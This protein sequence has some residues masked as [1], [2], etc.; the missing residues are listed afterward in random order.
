M[1]VHDLLNLIHIALHFNATQPVKKH[2]FWTEEDQQTLIKKKASHGGRK[3][4]HSVLKWMILEWNNQFKAILKL[5]QIQIPR[6]WF[7]A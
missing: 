5:K 7:L 3:W 6:K 4:I 1:G 2:T